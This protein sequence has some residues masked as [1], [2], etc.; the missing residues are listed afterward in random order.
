MQRNIEQ[1]VRYVMST[2]DKELMVPFRGTDVLVQ[3]LS[4]VESSTIIRKNVE[5]SRQVL[6]IIRE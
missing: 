4:Y 2:I 3:A 1:A 5:L 6:E